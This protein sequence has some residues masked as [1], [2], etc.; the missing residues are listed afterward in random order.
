MANPTITFEVLDSTGFTGSGVNGS[1]LGFF[2]SGGFG[3][4]VP[5][6]CYQGSTHLVNSDG[7]V[8]GGW[9]RNTEFIS[10]VLGSSG[11]RLNAGTTNQGLLANLNNTE[12]VL[13]IHFKNPDA[14]VNVQNVQLRIY[15]RVN[16]IDN[17][18]SGVITKVAE[19]VNFAGKSFSAW[20]ASPGAD[21]TGGTLSGGIYTGG[22]V[23]SGDAF[24]WGAPWADD[25]TY[26]GGSVTP[27]YQ[28]SI[29]LK[30]YNF[31]K[32]QDAA[33]G[34]PDQRLAGLTWPGKQTVGGTGLIVPLLNSPGSGGRGLCPPIKTD[35]LPKFFQYVTPARQ[36]DFGTV[37]SASSGTYMSRMYGGSATDYQHTWRV[38][39]SASPLNIGSKTLYGMY[40]SLEYL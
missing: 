6:N 5:L 40:I 39:I 19:I 33:G 27:Y 23:G 18:A 35:L 25:S 21:W 14:A 24:W 8:D 20:V 36:S 38:A 2:G 28:N 3:T 17:P 12:A 32:T 13:Q 16:S 15:D 31:T 22:V 10:G 4:S 26:G 9:V 11:V 1:G 34:N 29:G 7:S 30:F 37:T